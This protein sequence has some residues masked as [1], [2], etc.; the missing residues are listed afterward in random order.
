LHREALALWSKQRGS[1]DPQ[2]LSALH[3]LGVT[4]EAA[5]KLSEAEAVFRELLAG[6]RKRAGNE[7][8]E[9]LYAIRK[10]AM[11]MRLFQM[12][13]GF[14]MLRL[15]NFEKAIQWTEKSLNSPFVHAHAHAY[16][17]LA[18][19]HWHLGHK[20]EAR[21]MLAKGNTLVPPGRSDDA[22]AKAEN[23]WFPRLMARIHLDEAS[24]LI[25]PDPPGLGK[26]SEDN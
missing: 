21:A 1:D 9:T 20:D 4:L 11:C 5:G 13:K 22:L 15:R 24:A 18:M 25:R 23:K 10:L 16:A 6:W 12:C 7:D 19:A 17:I 3:R 14:S 8:P 2:T 26:A